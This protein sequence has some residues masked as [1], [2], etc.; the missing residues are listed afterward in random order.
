MAE[1]LLNLFTMRTIISAWRPLLLLLALHSAQLC[2]AQPGT[3]SWRSAW[4]TELTPSNYLTDARLDIARISAN[5]YAISGEQARGYNPANGLYS[6][7]NAAL[8]LLD[9]RTGDTVRTV[10]VPVNGIGSLLG[11][12]QTATGNGHLLGGYDTNY[13]TSVYGIPAYVGS[14]VVDVDTAGNRKVY[15]ALPEPGYTVGGG[16]LYLAPAAKRVVR[17]PDGYLQIS[18]LENR[19]SLLPATATRRYQRRPAA[20][21]HRT[22]QD[23]GSD[24]REWYDLTPLPTGAY[25]ATG[26]GY[27]PGPW[28]Q[29]WRKQPWLGWLTPQ[30]DTIRTRWVG[31]EGLVQY[32]VVSRATPDGGT[33][34]VGY[35]VPRTAGDMFDSRRAGLVLKLDSA[36]RR[37]WVTGVPDTSL[38][39]R[40]PG[41]GG[42]GDIIDVQPTQAG[43]YVLLLNYA[44]SAD[45]AAFGGRAYLIGVSA[46]GQVEW[47]RYVAGMPGF[48]P[49]AQAL[50]WDYSPDG[51]VAVLGLTGR[52]LPGRPPEGIHLITQYTGLPL[53]WVPDYC[54]R[55]PA[56]PQLTGNVQQPFPNFV[57]LPGDSTTAA[58]PRYAELSLCTWEWGDGSPVDT[59]WVGQHQ[60]LTPD[61]VRVR[62]CVTNSL[63]CQTCTEYFPLGPLGVAEELAASVQVW[64]NPSASGV[65]GVRN[66]AGKAGDGVW[67]VTDAVGRTVAQGA[68]APDGAETAVDLSREAA[69]LYL[70]RLTWPDGRRVQKRLARW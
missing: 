27:R 51:T 66:S 12:S 40:N 18:N 44:M 4:P 33:I 30:G 55:P 16:Y 64:P 49:G 37:E 47:K 10:P 3:L 23:W 35:Q 43:G 54:A 46:A 19:A 1:A 70:L 60:Y 13:V 68:L 57:I 42:Y 36:G 34:T 15:S 9:A 28:S 2:N 29:Y 65:F 26:W 56:A 32:P 17:L 62:Q 24:Y 6:R 14:V 61:P 53:P 11:F 25:L 7:L 58:G 5:R 38:V 52:Q 8:W 50:A 41:P 48:Y 67:V 39:H 69:G 63:F 59:G 31:Q 45:T 22:V 21:I 20:V